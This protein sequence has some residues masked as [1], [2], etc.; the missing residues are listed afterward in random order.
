MPFTR[1]TIFPVKNNFSLSDDFWQAFYQAEKSELSLQDFIS[2]KFVFSFGGIDSTLTYTG[3]HN[4]A[5]KYNVGS[6]TW[7]SIA[8]LPD[9]EAT[10]ASSASYVNGKIYI[11][12]G[13]TIE[14]N[15]N[16]VSSNK[17]LIYDVQN[18]TYL[19]Q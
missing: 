12:G 10:I 14:A 13:Y 19:A 18:D 7:E 4:K 2:E 11:M 3:V 17:V 6:D 9:N 5:W 16:E 8:D 15:G 1:F